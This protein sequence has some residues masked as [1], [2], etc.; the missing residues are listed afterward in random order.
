M[1]I[2]FLSIFSSSAA[3]QWGQSTMT[4]PH[5]PGTTRPGRRQ[6]E[7]FVRRNFVVEA[8]RGGA[9]ESWIAY[10]N[11]PQKIS[12]H[13]HTVIQMRVWK[14][15]DSRILVKLPAGSLTYLMQSLLLS[16]LVVPSLGQF[17]QL[18]ELETGLW[19]KSSS[20]KIVF[21]KDRHH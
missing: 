11:I 17:C 6:P 4:H 13:H 7:R 9:G 12:D 5:G 2:Q 8:G 10:D 21:K 18:G 19:W 14:S 16:W 20:G 15:M 1:S 3:G